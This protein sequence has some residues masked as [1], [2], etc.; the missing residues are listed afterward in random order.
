MDHRQQLRGDCHAC[1]GLCCVGSSFERSEWFA[2]DKPCDT[3]CPRLTE[4]NACDIHERLDE[5]GQAGCRS[6]DCYGAGQRV[7]ELY[8]GQSFRETPAMLEAFRRLVAIHELRFL[9]HEAGRLAL[10]APHARE[11]LRILSELEPRAGLGVDSLAQLDLG[12]L[13]QRAR[14]LLRSLH[15][16]FDAQPERRHLRVLA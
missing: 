15:V 7:C 9:L 11:R 8:S 16:Y 10:T 14:R 3:A 1:Q 12:R 13:E 5:E 6:Y 4:A 2:F